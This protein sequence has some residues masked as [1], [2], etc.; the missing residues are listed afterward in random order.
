[1]RLLAESLV[2]TPH[3]EWEAPELWLFKMRVSIHNHICSSGSGNGSGSVIADPSPAGSRT[4]SRPQVRP[5]SIQQCKEIMRDVVETRGRLLKTVKLEDTIEHQ[6]YRLF[7]KRY[8]LFTLVVRHAASFLTGLR[9]HAHTDVDCAVFLALF[10]NQV[11][12]SYLDT[13]SEAKERI[14][15]YFNQKIQLERQ[16]VRES[17]EFRTAIDELMS[18]TVTGSD[19]NVLI[20]QLFHIG[21]RPFVIS[22]VKKVMKTPKNNIHGVHSNKSGRNFSHIQPSLSSSSS[23][24]QPVSVSVSTPV[25]VNSTA[26]AR[27]LPRASALSKLS[28]QSQSQSSTRLGYSNLQTPPDATRRTG[29]GSASGSGYYD[30]ARPASQV[31]NEDRGNHVGRP[32]HA[33]PA[34]TTEHDRDENGLHG[35]VGTGF[36][37]YTTLVSVL[38]FSHLHLTRQALFALTHCFQFYDA[39]ADGVLSIPDC[40]ECLRNYCMEAFGGDHG[41]QPETYDLHEFEIFLSSIQLDRVKY[42]SF[43]NAV[44]ILRHLRSSSMS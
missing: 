28:V 33:L 3:S 24:F 34:P 17:A 5:L 42:I 19:A 41:D 10:R 22:A 31:R 8:G 12:E 15:S 27:Q 35:A 38:L 9:H 21:D 16:C 4:T 7:E 29:S 6:V 40:C 26:T 11:D 14:C 39:D 36:I 18:G 30:G 1:M 25:P 20:E 43:S 44:Y 13:L 37:S 32:P 2:L 23:P